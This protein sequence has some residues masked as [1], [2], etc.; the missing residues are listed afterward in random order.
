MTK[1]FLITNKELTKT[2]KKEKKNLY[3][4]NTRPGRNFKYLTN[5]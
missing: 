5:M 1:K 4:N 3:E 2:V